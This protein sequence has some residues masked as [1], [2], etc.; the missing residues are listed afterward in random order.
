MN[1]PKNE[2]RNQQ[3]N[4]RTNKQGINAQTMIRRKM[5]WCNIWTIPCS[6]CLLAVQSRMFN[7]IEFES[8]NTDYLCY[9]LRK[10]DLKSVIVLKIFWTCRSI[11]RKSIDIF[12]T[13][14]LR[15]KNRWE[16]RSSCWRHSK[17]HCLSSYLWWRGDEGAHFCIIWTNKKLL[18]R[19]GEELTQD[20]ATYRLTWPGYPFFVSGRS[21]PCGK[22]F[23]THVTLASHEDSRAWACSYRFVQ[24]KV[25]PRYVFKDIHIS[26]GPKC[27]FSWVFMYMLQMLI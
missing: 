19:I 24:D 17:L 23:P 20:D 5:C 13:H 12:Y 25:T 18:A 4:K 9:P 27:L 1:G 16:V 11:L 21:H 26:Y 2:Q 3:A 10:K 15:E 14:Q 7:F 22:F 6:R 8:E